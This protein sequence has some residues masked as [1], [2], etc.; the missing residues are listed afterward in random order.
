MTNPSPRNVCAVITSYNP[1]DGFKARVSLV[2]QQVQ[3]VLIVDNGSRVDRQPAIM[4]AGTIPNVSLLCNDAN[5]GIAAALNQGAQ[6]ASQK[7]YLG[8]VFF[9]QDSRVSE[10]V[11][12]TLLQVWGQFQPSDP[13][14]LIGSNFRNVESGKWYAGVAAQAGTWHD[15][16]VVLTSGSLLPLSSY[17]AIGPFREEF[18]IDS[19]DIEYCF[20]ARAKGYRIIQSLQPTMEHSAGHPTPHRFFGRMVWAVNHN[21]QRC[22]YMTRNPIVL[23]REYAFSHPRWALGTLAGLTKWMLKLV[24][25]EDNRVTKLRFIGSGV[26]HGLTNTFVNPRL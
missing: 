12:P 21:P 5:R 24:C 10:Q 7:G 3:A 17:R 16:D 15:T 19:V 22:Y 8:V 20:R 4:A 14:A 26:A 9:D 2:A 25:F 11:L 18:F 23:A 6:W 1:D 13:I